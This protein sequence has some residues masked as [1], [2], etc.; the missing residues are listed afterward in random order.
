MEPLN[1]TQELNM[2]KDTLMAPKK[3]GE[4]YYDLLD[5]SIKKFD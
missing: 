1:E 4:S 2:S 3:F 5:R